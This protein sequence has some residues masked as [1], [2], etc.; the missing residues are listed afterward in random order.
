[1]LKNF[2]KIAFRNLARNK[3]F[4]FINIFG[5]A[6]SMSVCL[7]VLLRIKDQVGYDKFHPHPER[8]YRIITQVTNKQGSAYRLATTPLPLAGNLS[9]DYN[10]I[11]KSVW[12]YPF[13]SKNAITETK[14]LNIN[15]AFTDPGFFDVFGFTLNSGDEH[16]AL[17]NPNSI[18]LNHETASMYFGKDDPIGKVL[19]F[20]EYGD[21]IVTGVMNKPAGKSHIDFQAFLSMSSVT[22]LERSGKLTSISEHWDD[23]ISA[24]TYVTLKQNTSAKQLSKAVAQVSSLLMKDTKVQGKESFAFE[25]QP[26]NKIILGEEDL[27]YSIGN[28]GSRG[29]MLA[30]VGISFILLLSACFNY[31]NLSLARSLKRGK[32]VG[33]RKVAGAFRFQIFYQFIIESI[34]IALL[35]L[36]VALLLFKIII[37]YLPFAG[38]LIPQDPVYDISLFSWFIGFSLFTGLLAGALPAWALSSFK[39]VEVLKNLSNIKLFGSNGLRK[40]LIVVQ[41]ALSLIIIVFTI[42]FFKQFKYMANG[43]P[44][45]NVKNII[46]IP[47]QGADYKLLSHD[48]A[49]LK[50]IESISATSD[51]LGRGA[52][53]SIAIKQAKEKEPILTEYY[54]VDKNFINNMRLTLI[55][56]NT[57]EDNIAGKEKQVIISEITQKILQFKTPSEAIAKMIFINDTTQVQIAGVIKDFY[58]RGMETPY[59]PLVLRNRPQEFKYLQVKYA[60]AND[61]A[62]VAL[63]ESIWKKT[64]PHKPFEGSNLYDEIHGRKSAWGTV[65]MLG[66]LA[67]ITITLACMGLL[68]MVVYNTETRK[69]EIGIRKVMGASVSGIITLLSKSFMRLVLLAGV[70]ALPVSYALSYFFLT[71]F[72]NRINISFGILASSFLIML[73]I[74]LITIGSH[75]YKVAI[76]NPVN[77]L[78]TE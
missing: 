39:P 41:F 22:A 29:K 57:F 44:G 17:I 50:E 27:A 16:T 3:M 28:T 40:T 15:A 74:S 18:V 76:G 51:N 4:S 65:S 60:A 14:E 7:I 32:E 23:G 36:G 61:K 31:T 12:L 43:D 25:I 5:L 72:A 58:Y 9:R 63:I 2:L 66:F 73:L 10:F 55:A 54:D 37:D 62:I 49:E 8:T 11:E 64:N 69:K 46:N 20:G 34:F 30:E 70:I 59:G 71:M 75:I 78:R 77:S 1:M 56:G 52:S 45:Y 26:L 47:L 48:I 68:G 33:V 38:E 21:F 13:G 19:S 6:L 67:I 24:Y 35:S 42:T 53:G